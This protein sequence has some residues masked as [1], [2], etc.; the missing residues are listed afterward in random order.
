MY[1]ELPEDAEG[2]AAASGVKKKKKKVAFAPE[3][4]KIRVIKQKRGGKK[5]VS[6][7]LGF[8][9]YGCDLPDVAKKISK[10]CGTGAAAMEI[11]YK[12]LKEDGI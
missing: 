6:S 10:R 7:I 12:G 11:D 1:P 5:I 9:K 2:A 4:A 8:D 3:A